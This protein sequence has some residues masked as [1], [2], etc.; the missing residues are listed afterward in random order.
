MAIFP[1][2]AIAAL[3]LGLNML[4]DALRD[5]LDTTSESAEPRRP[6]RVTAARRLLAFDRGRPR[7]RYARRVESGVEARTEPVRPE[8]ARVDDRAP[9]R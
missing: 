2:L 5:Q 4:G 6:E 3:V 1:G 8:R 9:A 7:R